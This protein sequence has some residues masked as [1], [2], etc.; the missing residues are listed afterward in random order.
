MIKLIA[1]FFFC[2]LSFFFLII[3][4]ADDGLFLFHLIFENLI[5]QIFITIFIIIIPCSGMFRV[6]QRPVE[7]ELQLCSVTTTFRTERLLLNMFPEYR[8][9]TMSNNTSSRLLLT[10]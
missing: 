10:L 8:V 6:Y 9:Q 5:F 1:I 2:F 3:F 4:R 7:T